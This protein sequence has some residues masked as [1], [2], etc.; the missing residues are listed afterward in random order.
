[1]SL[2]DGQGRELK[3]PNDKAQDEALS[4]TLAQFSVR[5]EVLEVM[6]TEL[7]TRCGMTREEVVAFLENVYSEVPDD[8]GDL[9][10]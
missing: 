1:M 3:L 9:A 6:V 7:A 10:G 8:A 5:I 4:Y 2:F